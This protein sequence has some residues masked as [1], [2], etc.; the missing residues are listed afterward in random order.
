MTDD[1]KDGAIMIKHEKIV[2]QLRDETEYAKKHFLV[3][4]TVY[5]AHP[6]E[7]LIQVGVVTLIVDAYYDHEELITALSARY[8]PKGKNICSCYI[9]LLGKDVIRQ[10]YERLFFKDKS[11]AHKEI[12]SRMEREIDIYEARILELKECVDKHKREISRL[13]EENK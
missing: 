6:W 7:D 9:A 3:G 13:Q 4:D 1:Q 11:K 8:R 12:V 2:R 5:R 10:T